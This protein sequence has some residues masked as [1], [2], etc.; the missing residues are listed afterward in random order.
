MF[1]KYHNTIIIILFIILVAI[2]LTDFNKSLKEDHFFRYKFDLQK[3]KVIKDLGTVEFTEVKHNSIKLVKT[4][5]LS[6]EKL[7]TYQATNLDGGTQFSFVFDRLEDL[8]GLIQLNAIAWY[9]SVPIDKTGVYNLKKVQLDRNEKGNKSV[10]MFIDDL[11][12]CFTQGKKM[13]YNMNMVNSNLLFEGN[14][15]DIYGYSYSGGNNLKSPD[16][17][18]IIKN[19]HITDYAILW[20]GRNN[21]NISIENTVEDFNIIIDHLENHQETKIILLTPA[22]SPVESYDIKIE[23][24]AEALNSIRNQKI[25]II[26]VYNLI[27]QQKNWKEEMFYNDY[28]LSDKAYKMIIET[29]DAKF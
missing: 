20:F 1:S 17:V 26:D 27:K 16:F 5:G 24:I 13:R 6:L 28:A 23:A 2:S 25:E 9:F 4:K 19:A 14:K 15:K 12:C 22:P 29:L 10:Q 21:T 18:E 11:G 8:N 3:T 7:Q